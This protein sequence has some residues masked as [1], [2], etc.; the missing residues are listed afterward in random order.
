[1]DPELRKGLEQ[2]G[3]LK[4]QTKKFG[5]STNDGVNFGMNLPNA[6]EL[7]RMRLMTEKLKSLGY[8]SI[9]PLSCSHALLLSCPRRRW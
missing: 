2:S 4:G 3:L 1:M 9:P 7:A 8:V 6:E 5:F